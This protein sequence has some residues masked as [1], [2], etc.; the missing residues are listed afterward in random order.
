ML[1]QLEKREPETIENYDKSFV[2]NIVQLDGNIS[3]TTTTDTTTS[4]ESEISDH[5]TDDEVDPLIVPANLVPI[6]GQN[7]NHDDPVIFDVAP[8][9]SNKSSFIPLC[10]I[11]NCRSLAN[12]GDNLTNILN[13]I[14]PDLILA[15]ETWERETLRMNEMI[16]S[17]SYKS[18]S[19]YRK[20]KSPGGGATIIYN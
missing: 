1:K 19:Y 20:N 3:I 2:S 14:S 5:N 16:K 7:V 11:I 4:D 8:P 15:S 12:K 9:L 17:N 13:Q 10:L 6:P 18:I